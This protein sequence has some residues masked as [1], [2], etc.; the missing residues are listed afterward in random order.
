VVVEGHEPG[1]FLLMASAD[2]GGVG[3]PVSGG[4]SLPG[5]GDGDVDAEH[6]GQD[7]GGQVSRELE[8]CG[9]AGLAGIDA[10]LAETFGQTIGADR[11]YVRRFG[12][13]AL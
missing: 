12:D 8:Q 10:V 1:F 7:R 11:A 13:F 3:G 4:G 2:L 5:D 6:A 9:G